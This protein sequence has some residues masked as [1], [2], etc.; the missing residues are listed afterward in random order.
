MTT[1]PNITISKPDDDLLKSAVE[2][3]YNDF[4]NKYLYTLPGTWDI[5]MK[6]KKLTFSAIREK[7]VENGYSVSEANRYYGQESSIESDAPII[8][9]TIN[10]NGNVKYYP[11]YIGEIKK[12]GTNDKRLEEGEK[13]QSQGNAAGDRTAKNYNIIADYCYLCNRVFFPYNVYLH[14]FDFSEGEI[15]KTTKAKLEP[16]FGTLNEFHPYFYEVCGNHKGGSCFYQKDMFTLE[17]IYNNCSECCR[18]GMEY[19]LK[20]F[21]ISNT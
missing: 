17:Q 20:H 5:I 2:K 14:G 6:N 9:L 18:V 11:L 12:Q 3:V 15:R 1:N 13:R 19:Y 7:M 8:Y 21:G 10:N 16:F 4:R